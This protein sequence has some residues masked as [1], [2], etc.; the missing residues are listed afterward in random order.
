M[1]NI[2]YVLTNPAM[3]GFVKIGMTDGPDVQ[4]RM[5][6]LYTTG[7]PFPFECAIA[8]EIDG[9][10]A[11]EIEAALHTAFGPQR[12]NPSREFFEMDPEQVQVILRV[13]PGRDVTPR[14]AAAAEDSRDEDQAAASEY[15]VRRTRTDELQFLESLNGPGRR[16][17]ERVLALGRPDDMLV[18]WGQKGF[19]LNVLANGKRIGICY[20]YPPSAYNQGLYTEFAGINEKTHISPDAISTL[21]S[22][23]LATGLFIPAGRGDE[24]R[25]ATDNHLDEHQLTSVVDWLTDMATTIRE[26]EVQESSED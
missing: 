13:I 11:E 16:F 21:R 15:K 23:A 17:Y 1:P 19:S 4:A 7:V 6:S 9:R 22:D 18:R 20:G 2:V 12:A 26:L 24:L 5:N 8:W 10:S 3:P 14:P 25:C